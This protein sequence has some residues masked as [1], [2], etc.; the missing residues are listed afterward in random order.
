MM[1]KMRNK[2][3]ERAFNRVIRLARARGKLACRARYERAIVIS[4]QREHE[5]AANSF[6][7]AIDRCSAPDILV[8]AIYRGAKAFQAAAIYHEAIRLYGLVE[9]DFSSHSFADDARLHSA[10]CHLA[11]GERDKFIEMLESLPDAYPAGDMRAEALWAVSHDALKRNELRDA[12]EALERYYTMFPKESG[13]YASGRSGYW[14]GRVEE[15][16]GDIESAALRYE[17]VISGSPL[18]FYMV[19]AYNRL[20]A[21]DHKRA[22]RLIEELAPRGGKIKA[23]FPR[24]LLDDFPGLATGI[25]LYR[26]GLLTLARRELDQLLTQPNLPPEVHWLTAAVLRQAGKFHEAKAAATGA[27]SGWNGRYPTGRDFVH[28]SLAYPTAYEDEV[29]E[30]ASQTDVEPAMIWA[31]MREESSF[32]P[33]IESWAN[34]IGL[35]Q[36]ILP[37]ARSMGKRLGIPANRRTLRRPDVNI[38]LGTAYL[39]LLRKKF[40]DH[41]ALMIAGYNAGE[42]AVGKWARARPGDDIDIFIEDIPYDQTRGY[43]KRVIATFATYLFLYGETRS[44]LELDL[45]LP[46]IR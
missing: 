28:W 30:A 35:M 17:Q 21:I 33:E 39:E 36:L 37:T 4:R 29:N 6:K 19:L 3:A 2:E 9:S 7:K 38:R 31:V 42:G 26:L 24:S 25:E 12:R 10:R 23:R 40:D 46:A 8:R 34:A 20:A 15:R 32:N 18:T 1:R 44:I 11:L 43:T 13:W 41:P 45:K 14:F 5:R 16:L 27:G 22:R